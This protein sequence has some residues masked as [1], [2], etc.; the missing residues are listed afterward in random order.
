[1]RIESPENIRENTLLQ[2]VHQSVSFFSRQLSHHIATSAN[3]I[4][5]SFDVIQGTLNF[6]FASFH[7]VNGSIYLVLGPLY[8]I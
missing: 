6:V 4:T 7:I 5:L 8:T 2:I 1:M 3:F